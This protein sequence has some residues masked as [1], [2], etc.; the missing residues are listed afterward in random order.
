[1]LCSECTQMNRQRIINWPLFI[2]QIQI[3]LACLVPDIEELNIPFS[4]QSLIRNAHSPHYLCLLTTLSVPL[5]FHEVPRILGPCLVLL[6]AMQTCFLSVWN[7][8][9]ERGSYLS[10]QFP[11]R[12]TFCSKSAFRMHSVV[13]QLSKS[14]RSVFRFRY[15]EHWRPF[16]SMDD[17]FLPEGSS[18]FHIIP[19]SRVA[20]RVRAHSL[21]QCQHY[22][23]L[24]VC[25][26]YPLP[27]LATT[28]RPI[29]RTKQFVRWR[30]L[31]YGL[32]Q[33]G[34]VW[35]RR[36]H[37]LEM[38]VRSVPQRYLQRAGLPIRPITL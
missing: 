17:G 24:F 31:I 8:R 5:L 35:Q 19:C 28:W 36:A 23:W 34:K 25:E 1:M 30:R 27:Y 37:F 16:H 7:G 2:H 3:Q 38:N 6:H 9:M 14:T 32:L 21:E 26:L 18:I 12:P 11:K 29:L 13:F 22:Q 4:V 33:R 10:C 20:D 15:P